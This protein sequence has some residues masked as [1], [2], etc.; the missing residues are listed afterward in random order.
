MQFDELPRIGKSDSA[1]FL[2]M[3]PLVE[4][5]KKPGR[6]HMSQSDSLIGDT[7]SHHTVAALRANLDFCA[8][9]T[10][11]Q[12][13]G[14]QV[15]YDDPQFGIVERYDV[16]LFIGNKNEIDAIFGK[17]FGERIDELAEPRVE[18][19]AG[20]RYAESAL[21]ELVDIQHHIDDILHVACLVVDVRETLLCRIVVSESFQQSSQRG[22]DQRQ[23]RTQFVA[24]IHEKLNL[25][26]IDFLFVFLESP[27]EFR[28]AAPMHETDD[29]YGA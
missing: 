20:R 6:I 10:E 19:S 4:T 27:T 24:D 18:R 3:I 5:G 26:F 17:F 1:A 2:V 11:F 9:R 25:L 13:I 29:R 12:G 23:G 7:D 21:V 8:G 14:Q 15:R 28:F 16:H 22:V